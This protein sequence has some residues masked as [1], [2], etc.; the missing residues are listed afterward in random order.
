MRAEG[1]LGLGLLTFFGEERRGV[2]VSKGRVNVL[3]PFKFE[4]HL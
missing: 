3:E 4:Y 1:R 2:N